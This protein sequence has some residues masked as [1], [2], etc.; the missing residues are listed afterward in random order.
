MLLSDVATVNLKAI[1]PKAA[2]ATC[3]LYRH[4]VGLADWI[5]ADQEFAF[6][7]APCWARQIVR[8]GDAIGPRTSLNTGTSKPETCRH[9]RKQPTWP[10]LKAHRRRLLCRH[11]IEAFVKALVE[12]YCQRAISHS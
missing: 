5:D 9:G 4:R 1:K 7:E 2:P 10:I 3:L 8:D 12:P 6:A 11:N